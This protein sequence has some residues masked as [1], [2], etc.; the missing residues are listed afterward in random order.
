MTWGVALHDPQLKT[1]HGTRACGR[2]S[3]VHLAGED[4]R[5]FVEPI[6]SLQWRSCLGKTTEK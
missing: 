3:P 1:G 2:L 4:R 5:A 6:S